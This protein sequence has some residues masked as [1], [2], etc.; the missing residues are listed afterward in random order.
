MLNNSSLKMLTTFS[1]WALIGVGQPS[2]SSAA[3]V[4]M[5]G[6][7]CGEERGGSSRWTAP[8]LVRTGNSYLENLTD[9]SLANAM[10]CY[11]HTLQI[12]PEDYGAHLGLG[13]A[14]IM[15]ARLTGERE[16]LKTARTHLALALAIRPFHFETVYYLAE[17]AVL[18]EKY[19]IAKELL[20]PLLKAGYKKGPVNTLAGDVYIH[21][22]EEKLARQY[23]AIGADEGWPESTA[24]YAAER[25]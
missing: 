9:S 5:T 6:S 16:Y 7:I 10:I 23:Y 4:A 17:L 11:R 18:E 22:G 1:L 19:T 13:A 3:G 25:R 12:N 21:L 24:R 20:T 15:K 14:N 2:P 8:D